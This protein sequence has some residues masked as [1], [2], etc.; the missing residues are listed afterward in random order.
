MTASFTAENE[1]ETERLGRAL[2]ENLEPG[3]VVGLLGPLGAGK[4]RLVRSVA[5]AL[6]VDSAAVASPTFVLIREYQGKTPIY[7]FDVYRLRDDDEFQE[8]GP[9]E[10][11]DS[12][13]LSFVE[14][15]DRVESLLPPDRLDIRITVLSP[16]RRQFDLLPQGDFSPEIVQRIAGKITGNIAGGN[17]R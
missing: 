8:L 5:E 2:A 1:R 4:T 9:D 6:G 14:W 3:T 12:D 7:H 10:Y 15:A 11:F 13:G 16:T 17:E